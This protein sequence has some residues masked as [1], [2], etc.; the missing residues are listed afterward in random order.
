[1]F[2]STCL[3]CPR[4][5]H[6]TAPPLW[7]RLGF[8]LPAS[9]NAL[10]CIAAGT[11]DSTPTTAKNEHDASTKAN[12]LF[13]LARPCQPTD[14]SGTHSSMFLLLPFGSLLISFGLPRLRAPPLASIRSSR[15]IYSSQ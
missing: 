11:P 5:Y 15:V 6:R 14:P 1:M 7:L 4:S 3:P 8:L 13:S 9:G 10:V 12:L 2:S